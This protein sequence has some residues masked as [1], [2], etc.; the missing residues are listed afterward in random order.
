MSPLSATVTLVTGFPTSFL[1]RRVVS[2]L[3]DDGSDASV[4]V[5]VQSQHTDRARALLSELTAEQAARVELFEGDAAAMDLGLS[6]QEFMRLASEVTH[7]H[8]CAAITYFGVNPEMARHVNL[9]GTREVLEL[10]QE[11]SGLR[12]LV[13]W[14]SAMV[15]GAR[16]GYVLEKELDGTAGFRNVIE[17]TRFA[18]EHTVRRMAESVPVTILRPAIVVG[19][20]ITGEINRLEGPYLLVMLMLGAPADLRVPLPGRGDIP[21]NL[22]PID[23]V[24]DAGLTI[25]RDQR[26]LGKTFHLVDPS[27]MS[28]KRVF[29]LIARAADRP[30]PRGSLPTNIATAL[31][32]TPGVER[33]AQVP[34]AFLEQLATEVV[35]DDR[36]ARALLAGCDISCPAFDQYVDVMVEYVRRHQASQRKVERGRSPSSSSA[37][38]S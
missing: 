1:A 5:I 25:A 11:A 20:S 38:S 35:Y 31:L 28:A 13:H 12:R 15:S 27:P 33:F 7:I 16:R 19:D 14:S 34:R 24:V 30:P 9:Q 18:A 17:E 36:N 32:R 26:S 4:K 21:L 10:A 2:K 3:L 29:D 37:T 23:Y 8:H 6:G 22:V